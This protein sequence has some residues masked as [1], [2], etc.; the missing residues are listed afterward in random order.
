MVM[1]VNSTVKVVEV[2][3]M[4]VMLDLYVRMN[5]HKD[6]QVQ[7]NFSMMEKMIFYLHYRMNHRNEFYSMISIENDELMIVYDHE[8][9]DENAIDRIRLV[10]DEMRDAKEQV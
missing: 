4:S 5:K 7:S 10:Q 2:P 1:G 6:D 8:H 3:L 9:E